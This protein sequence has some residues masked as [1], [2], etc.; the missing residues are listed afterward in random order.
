MFLHFIDST[1]QFNSPSIILLKFVISKIKHLYRGLWGSPRLDCTLE[2]T[3]NTQ[4][5]DW[6]ENFVIN[7]ST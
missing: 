7:V 3:H 1:G 5:A 4:Y 2:S 6:S